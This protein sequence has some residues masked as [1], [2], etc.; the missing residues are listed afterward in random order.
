[1]SLSRATAISL[2]VAGAF[3]MENLDGTVI[4]TALPQMAASFGAHPVD[5][6]IGVSAYILTLAV[7][8]PA[9][10]WLADRFGARTI[11][12]S[13][14]LIFTLASVA[15]GLSSNLVFFV[16]ARVLQ[17]VGGAMM[18]PV[19]RLVVLKAARKEEIIS[20][21]G[22]I[23]WPGLAAPVL[24][25]PLGGFIT[26]YFS[27]HWIFYLNVPLGAVAL[28]F[29]LR[30]VPDSEPEPRP[31]DWPGF[32]LTGG[33]GFTLML[34]IQLL[35][36]NA[37]PWHVIAFLLFCGLAFGS[38]A[39]R[40][41]RRSAH[42]V[43]DLYALRYKSFAVT[44][45]GGT[46]FRAAIGAVPFLLPLLFQIGFGLDPF[47]SGLLVLSV[48][49]GNLAMKAVTTP[50]LHRFGFR[51]VLVVNGLLNGAVLLAC[52]FISPETPVP[53]I[54]ALLFV[55]GL[56][57][58]MQFTTISTVAF[59]DVP[60]DR[61]SGA[62]T[63]LNVVAPIGFALGIAVAALALRIATLVFPSTD[64]VLSL[65]QFHLAFVIIAAIAFLAVLDTLG[66]AADVGD[67]LRKPRVV[68]A[69]PTQMQESLGK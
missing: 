38:L 25:P 69:S 14:I 39:V 56:T 48:F 55:S 61:M 28:Y 21:I 62:N 41:E 19:G 29:A 42:P 33:C 10:G 44:V 7:L 47:V 64:G 11:F 22:L 63:L 51:R 49:A 8:I 9:S 46:L 36:E 45:W 4:V 20:A 32:V 43:V 31:F 27:W 37:P 67:S 52:A 18:V 40:A 34:G 13:A 54:V 50:I 6:S 15:C 30:L 3:F 53:L 24:G 5:L 1:M 58:S 16:I 68:A 59:A 65:M 26:T 66:L 60:Q 57:R 12:A 17:G 2:L 35:S 23:V